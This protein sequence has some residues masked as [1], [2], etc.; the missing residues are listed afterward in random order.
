MRRWLG[1]AASAALITTALTGCGTPAGTDGDL[2]DDWR[3]VAEARQFTPEVGDCHVIADPTSYLTSYQPVDCTRSHLVETYHLGTF[4]GALAERPIPPKVGST[5]L[6]TAFAE[7]DAK[8]T[9]F[10]GGDWRGARLTVQVVPPSPA[11]WSGGSRW[12]RCDLLELDAVDGG[13]AINNHYDHAVQ[14]SASLRDELKRPSKVAYGCLDEDEYENL[15]HSS[16]DKPHRFEY[17]G[18]WTAPDGPYGDVARN[19]DNVHAKCRTVVARYAK[20]PVDGNLRYRTGTAYRLPSE[21]AWARGD[22][23]V[24]CFFWSG[25]PKLTR[26]IKGGGTKVL[27]VS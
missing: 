3:P 21:K 13:T 24:R 23:G 5:A 18:S 6:R 11:G 20:V 14:R 15:Q 22:R 16:C 12:Y 10:V 26:S 19:D 25:G 8:A 1:A 27:P 4:T 7:C 2:T 17:V 9:A